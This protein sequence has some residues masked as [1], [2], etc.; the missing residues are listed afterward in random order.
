[1]STGHLPRMSNDAF[2]GFLRL[3]LTPLNEMP[4]PSSE[5]QAYLAY[6]NHATHGKPLDPP[7]ARVARRKSA[8][9]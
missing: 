9:A 1:M 5:L 8:S 2:A 7:S 4:S 6:L 3:L